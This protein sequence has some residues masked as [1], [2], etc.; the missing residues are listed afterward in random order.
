LDVRKEE[1]ER[2]RLQGNTEGRKETKKKL[3]Q[4]NCTGLGFEVLTSWLKRV[5][6]SGI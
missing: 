2:E 3:A 6:S 4:R 1:K 5:L